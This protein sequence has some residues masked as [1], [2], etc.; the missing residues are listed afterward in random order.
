MFWECLVLLLADLFEVGAPVVEIVVVRAVVVCLT[1]P[2]L[3]LVV[4]LV[5]GVLP[6]VG[7][8]WHTIA[9]CFAMCV[10]PMLVVVAGDLF[11][12]VGIVA[13]IFEVEGW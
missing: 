7:C 3:H 11:A 10:Y 6:S 9:N 1:A 8:W 4:V 2:V 12:I 5:F 13:D